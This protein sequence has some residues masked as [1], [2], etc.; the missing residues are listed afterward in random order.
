MEDKLVEIIENAIP[1]IRRQQPNKALQI[2]CYMLDY[3]YIERGNI[4]GDGTC[5]ITDKNVQIDLYYSNKSA[6]VAAKNSLK[7]ELIK[8]KLFQ[9]LEAYYDTT[10]KYYR[11]TFQ[12]VAQEREE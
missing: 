11:A 2:P 1:N 6:F 4:Y 8:N 9:G 3:G 7:K 10:S 12:L 5:E